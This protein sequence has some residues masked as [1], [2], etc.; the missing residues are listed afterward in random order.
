MILWKKMTDLL[1]TKKLSLGKGAGVFATDYAG[2]SIPVGI[3]AVENRAVATTLTADDNGKIIL[4]NSTTAFA[5]TLPLPAIGLRFR[6]IVKAIP[7]SGSHTIVT[8][9]SANII[10]GGI[11]SSDL[12]SATDS[13]TS[14][15]GDTIGFV[16]AKTIA[17]DWVE[18]VSDGTSWFLR[19]NAAVFDAITLAAT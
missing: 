9:G 5:T 18:V 2:A 3:G 8:N 15:G 10:K 7:A 12:S 1:V 6:F 17:G 4:L 16:T 19:G 13:A 11:G 14:T